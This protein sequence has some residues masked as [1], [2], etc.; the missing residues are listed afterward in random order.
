[1][2]IEWLC[3]EDAANLGHFFKGLGLCGI[4][5]MMIVCLKEIK[6]WR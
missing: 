2:I 4:A 6:K 3:S 5:I 1:M